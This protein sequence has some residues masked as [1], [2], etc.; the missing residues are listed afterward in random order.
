MRAHDEDPKLLA[1]TLSKHYT[2]DSTAP[3]S[4]SRSVVNYIQPRWVGSKV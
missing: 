2:V 3:E 1:S 4:G